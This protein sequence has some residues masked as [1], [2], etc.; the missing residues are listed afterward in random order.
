MTTQSLPPSLTHSLTHSLAHSPT[1]AL[2]HYLPLT[3]YEQLSAQFGPS[4]TP[5]MRPVYSQ[6]GG[7]DLLSCLV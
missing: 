5:Y 4:L 2:T 7:R 3:R 1:H 6:S